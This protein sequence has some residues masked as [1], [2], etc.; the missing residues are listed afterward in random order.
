[1]LP[2]R[3]TLKTILVI[4]IAL[5]IGLLITVFLQYR[6][7]AEDPTRL[8]DAIPEGTDISI[9]EIKHTAIRDGRKEWSLEASSANYSDDAKTAVFEDVQA[10]MFMEDGR[11]VA[12]EGQQGKLDTETN[13]IEISGNVIVQDADYQLAAETINYDHEQR[14]IH[15]PVPVAITGKTFKLTAREMTVDLTSETAHLKGAVE[16]VFS[17]NN[18]L[19]F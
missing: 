15:I 13:N 4:G 10:V 11:E 18:T 17:G 7:Y 14:R 19:R 1:M 12:I 9:G 2:S 8:I 3:R 16:G 6:K 5:I